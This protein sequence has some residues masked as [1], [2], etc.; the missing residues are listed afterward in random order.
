MAL[1]YGWDLQRRD[2]RTG[3]SLIGS[4][5]K[6]SELRWEI[7]AGSSPKTTRYLR[8]QSAATAMGI[9]RNHIGNNQHTTKPGALSTIWTYS[10]KYD[11]QQKEACKT[12]FLWHIKTENR[13]IILTKQNRRNLQT[14]KSWRDGIGKVKGHSEDQP[15]ESFLPILRDGINIDKGDALELG[16]TWFLKSSTFY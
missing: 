14:S 3:S 16:W 5:I 2:P 8:T 4:I 7:K 1:L 9:L 6:R 13:E 15:K 12:Q 11:N 10:G